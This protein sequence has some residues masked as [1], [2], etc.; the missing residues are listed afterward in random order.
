MSMFKVLT[1]LHETVIDKNGNI[2]DEFDTNLK[3]HDQIASEICKSWNEAN[4]SQYYDG[5]LKDN[6]VSCKMTCTQDKTSKE[7]IAV[8]T[9]VMKPGLRLTKKYK[10]AIIEQTSAQFSDGWGEGFFG[11]ANIMEDDNGQQFFVE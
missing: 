2:Q 11:A 9:F 5:I 7:S 1:N 3:H 4:M 6:I 10:D 8:I